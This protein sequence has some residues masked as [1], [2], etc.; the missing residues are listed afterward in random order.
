MVTKIQKGGSITCD[1][2]RELKEELKQLQLLKM[3]ELRNCLEIVDLDKTGNKSELIGRLSR[4]ILDNSRDVSDIKVEVEKKMEK[5][6]L[7]GAQE[8]AG[9][10]FDSVA[11]ETES[12]LYP[13]VDPESKCKKFLIKYDLRRFKGSKGSVKKLNKWCKKY[14]TKK[15]SY[16][17]DVQKI[18]K[19]ADSDFQTAQ[20]FFETIP[21]NKVN[22][23][24][25]RKTI[26]KFTSARDNYQLFIRK[27]SFS[28]RNIFTYDLTKIL[29]NFSIVNSILNYVGYEHA[30]N[31]R[32]QRALSNHRISEI[33]SI[34][35]T[36]ELELGVLNG[37]KKGVT[38]KKKK[39]G[40]IDALSQDAVKYQDIFKG[41]EVWAKPTSVYDGDTLTVNVMFP[42][43]GVELSDSEP[44]KQFLVS[45]KIRCDG[46]DT[47]EMK[48]K[49]K[50]EKQTAF[51]AKKAFERKIGFVSNKDIE[52]NKPVLVQMKGL[53]KYGRLLAE[54]YI[55]NG[56]EKQSM[57]TFMLDEHFAYSYGGA[58]KDCDSF[59]EKY[60]KEI[61]SKKDALK[62]DADEEKKYKSIS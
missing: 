19:K 52:A 13:T 28:A 38:I 11:E 31:R 14:Y 51:I 57:T 1:R 40:E 54:V 2:I 10:M 49:T 29:P 17:T 8:S 6:D 50:Y 45:M 62:F 4:F 24:H 58:T 12:T 43:I 30:R 55:V 21:L 41:K 25:L 61:L 42:P 26:G 37:D 56:R 3:E 7:A 60:G 35:Y 22:K 15:K 32:V 53:D 39:A 48:G 44:M 20:D 9:R 47:P 33:N 59:L 18:L 23:S 27:T 34:I 5:G 46:Y 16:H 36:L